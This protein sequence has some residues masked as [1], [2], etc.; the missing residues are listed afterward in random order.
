LN[1]LVILGLWV[2]VAELSRQVLVGQTWLPDNVIGPSLVIDKGKSVFHSLLL[3]SCPNR[4][5]VLFILDC[6]NHWA[7]DWNE[8]FEFVDSLEALLAQLLPNALAPSSLLVALLLHEWLLAFAE[9]LLESTSV[10]AREGLARALSSSL[11]LSPCNRVSDSAVP[12][13]KLPSNSS[14][15]CVCVKDFIN[16]S[17]VATAAVS[18]Y[19]L[20]ND[21][22]WLW[23][24]LAEFSTTL[25]AAGINIVLSVA[26]AR[27]RGHELVCWTLIG[28]M[29]ALTGQ[30]AFH[31]L[32]AHEG[33]VHAAVA[34]VL[35]GV[36]SKVVARWDRDAT[37]LSG[38]AESPLG[39]V[40]APAE[41]V[42]CKDASSADLEVFHAHAKA[43]LGVSGGGRTL[44]EH[45][46][47]L[48]LASLSVGADT[49]P[50]D[51]RE[52]V[53][54]CG[55]LGLPDADL[56]ILNEARL[57][58]WGFGYNG[59]LCL[60]VGLLSLLSSLLSLLS[61]L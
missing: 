26:P 48:W 13:S 28:H 45:C 4:N 54:A 21:A 19:S 9:A 3:W 50:A 1:V 57:V 43:R 46:P 56:G 55:H 8:S 5:I 24:A 6:G 29:S 40:L 16:R 30:D 49:G 59:A 44:W 27:S 12:P 22:A 41:Q 39:L 32:A 2:K 10:L 25:V 53:L 36:G 37:A 42:L 60:L 47:E 51:V 38:G 11:E 23:L 61:L 18:N 17:P 31:S 14:L 35:V 15:Q 7:V 33:V 34:L 58:A 52:L 20:S